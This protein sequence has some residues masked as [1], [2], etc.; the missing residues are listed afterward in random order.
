[1]CRVYTCGGGGANN[2]R[3]ELVAIDWRCPYWLLTS[4]SLACF[5]GKTPTFPSKYE[6]RAGTGLCT[7]YAESM[8]CTPFLIS[9][10]DSNGPHKM[11][12]AS[13]TTPN[14]TANMFMVI[15]SLAY[16]HP[17]PERRSAHC[18]VSCICMWHSSVLLHLRIVVNWITKYLNPLRFIIVA[19]WN[20]PSI[21]ILFINNY[22]SRRMIS[23]SA[24]AFVWLAS[25]EC[26]CVA[27]LFA[28]CICVC[29]C[30]SIAGILFLRFVHA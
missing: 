18:N 30:S 11:P 27:H 21:I 28:R 4:L 15:L 5:W 25:P 1:M 6:A 17:I 23:V 29:A 22:V 16:A 12:L 19:E 13:N 20:R 9:S 14:A 24:L 26:Y 10:C 3:F 7:P 2:I 8:R